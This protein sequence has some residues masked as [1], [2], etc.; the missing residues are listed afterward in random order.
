[1]PNVTLP[2]LID[3]H[4]H[5]REPGQSHKEDFYSGT[6]AALAGGYTTIVDMPNNAVPITSEKLLNQKIALASQKTVCDLGFNFGTLGNNFD[7]FP[8]VFDKVNG[9]KIY[10]NMTTG[11]FIVDKSKLAEIYKAWQSEKPIFLHAEN[12]VS[13]LVL[14]TLRAI[15]RRTHI[16]HVSGQAELEFVM[17]AKDEGLPITCGVTPHHLFLNDQDREKLGSFGHMKP[18]LKAESDR[19]F[20]WNHLDG[21]DIIESDHAPHTKKEK[22]SDNPPFGVPGLETT[23]PLMLTAE[24]EGKITRRQ[25]L[26]KLHFAPSKLIDIIPDEST[27]I[28]VSMNEY[29][30]K[31][32][33]LLTKAGW[34]PFVGKKVIGK[35]KKAY[36]H[37][38]LVFENGNVLSAP[39]SGKIIS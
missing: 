9:L 5:L 26:D 35:V 25:L 30:I 14:S 29:E 1:M 6:S 20:L 31:N 7:E 11:G 8:A 36:I 33:D 34:S 16:C 10:L 2:G 21:F 4:V 24:A 15:P 27:K 19:K 13:D 32:E 22:L 23:L 3:P 28:E 37:G 18:Y 39:G 38:N 17:K 12:D